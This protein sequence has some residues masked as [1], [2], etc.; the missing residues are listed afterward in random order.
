MPRELRR[1]FAIFAALTVLVAAGCASPGFVYQRLDTFLGWRLNDYVTLNAEQKALYRLQ[2]NE[3]WRWNRQAQ[4]PAY[5]ADMRE[6]AAALDRSVAPEDTGRFVERFRG[7]WK[8]L[9]TRTVAG[10]CPVMQSLSEAQTRQILEEVDDGTERYQREAVKPPLRERQRASEREM[11]KWIRR[12]SGPLNARQRELVARWAEQR[13]DTSRQWLDYRQSWRA[14]FELALSERRDS[15]RCEVFE[16]LFVTP[17]AA[18]SEAL[19]AA[20]A[21]NEE[22]WR[23]LI[24]DFIAAAEPEQIAHAQRELREFAEQLDELARDPGR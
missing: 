20:M 7:H 18:R 13:R 3:L 6:A 4:L 17:G 23:K 16:P 12:W 8:D 24:A 14:R 1:G 9:M 19:Q 10:L 11:T 21:H 22:L 15:P 2:F 5:A